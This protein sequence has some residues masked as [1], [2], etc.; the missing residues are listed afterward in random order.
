MGHHHN[1]DDEHDPMPFY[2][3]ANKLID[4]WMK[5]NDDH[6]AEYR[7]WA[8]TFRQHELGAAAEIL[9]AAAGLNEQINMA[10]DQAKEE[11]VTGV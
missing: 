2:E 1:H 3:K 11:I 7:R 8:A 4:H 6:A 9:E 10:L 5:H